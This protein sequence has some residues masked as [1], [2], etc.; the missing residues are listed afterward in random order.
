MVASDPNP[1]ARNDREVLDVIDADVLDSSH[2]GPLALRGSVLR[3]SAYVAGILLSLISAP[4][5]IRHLGRV[6]YGRYIVVLALVAIVGGLTEGGVNAVA[7]REYAG[8]SGAERDRLMANLLGIRMVMSIVGVGGAVLFAALA[9]YGRELVLGTFLAGLGM[10]LQVTQDLLAVSL[11]A[12]LR[13]GWVTLVEFARQLVGVALII[14]LVVAG[15]HLFGFF[16]A[17]IPAGLVAVLLSARLVRGLFPLRPAFHFGM[18]RRLLGDTFVYAVAIA[19]NSVYFR[20]TVVIMSLV[21]SVSQTGYFAVSFRVVEVLIAVPAL[22]M[23]AAYPILTRAQR[24]DHERFLHATRRMFELAVLIGAWVALGLELGAGFIVE[25]LGG[26]AEAPAAAVLRIQGLAVMFTF[27]AVACAYP[28]LSRNRRHELV[29]ANVL[30]LVAA[31]LLSLILIPVLAAKGAA[32]A[33]VGAEATLMLVTAGA[34]TRTT[35]GLRLPLGV[36]PVAAFAAVVGGAAGYLA[37]VHPVFQVV[38]G[39]C[40]YLAIVVLLGRFPPELGH[41][42][43]GPGSRGSTGAASR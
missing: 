1:P 31:L 28:M 43:W 40:A 26:Q 27:M 21:A 42:I 25:V 12:T 32:V 35:P 20:V 9:G 23:G 38:V 2:A 3:S 4:L 34:L 5:L 15:S 36:L 18:V 14:A 29:L 33:T 13:F 17:T 24:D 7:L 37:G 39:S 16:V 11:Q 22:V 30:G 6:E 8:S 19:L 41:A 10:S